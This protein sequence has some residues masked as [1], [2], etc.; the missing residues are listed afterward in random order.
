MGRAAFSFFLQRKFFETPVLFF[1]VL[2]Y[3]GEKI[4]DER[5]T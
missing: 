2:K 4:L 3:L 1:V 5:T